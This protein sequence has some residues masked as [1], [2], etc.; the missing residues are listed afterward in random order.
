MKVHF[1]DLSVMK[2]FASIVS[3]ISIPVSFLVII[4]PLP[5]T[6][7]KWIALVILTSLFIILYICTWLYIKYRR[8]VSITINNTKVIIKEG[9]LFHEKG[10][11]VIPANEYF[12]TIVGDG[13]VD[14]NSLHAK[15]I[16]SFAQVTPD[17]LNIKIHE[18]LI[19]KAL[20]GIDQKE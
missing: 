5:D 18:A 19:H 10:N 14:P 1:F 4:Y 9:D 6:F 16:Q 20:N 15:Y 13:I 7:P 11:K 2:S 8:Q 17:E 12:D 3:G